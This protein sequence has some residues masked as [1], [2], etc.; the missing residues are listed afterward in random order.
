MD[1]QSIIQST[2]LKNRYTINDNSCEE[3][4]CEC[5]VVKTDREKTQLRSIAIIVLLAFAC[6]LSLTILKINAAETGLQTDKA[7]TIAC[8]LQ[9]DKQT[10]KKIFSYND[11]QSN[12]NNNGNCP[13]PSAY[14][15]LGCCNDSKR[16]KNQVC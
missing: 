4:I 7:E 11:Y 5:D 15:V 10:R 3:E 6:A 13:H 8:G 1:R 12:K 16:K 2:Y 9:S 14:S